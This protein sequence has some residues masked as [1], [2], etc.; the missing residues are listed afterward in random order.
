MGDGYMF[1]SGASDD[2][3]ALRDEAVRQL[4][5]G[6]KARW[7]DDYGGLARVAYEVG[8]DAAMLYLLSKIGEQ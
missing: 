4:T 3:L 5:D 6:A 2:I 1:S 7:G 8:W